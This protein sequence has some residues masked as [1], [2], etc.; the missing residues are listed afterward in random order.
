MS[1]DEILQKRRYVRR[2]DKNAK[3]PE[4]LINSLLQRTWRVT[5]SKNN[6]MPYMVHVIG[7]KPEHQKYKEAVYLNAAQNEGNH[8]GVPDPLNERYSENL[9]NYHNILNC[10]YLIIPTLRLE[11][12]PNRFQQYLI[13]RGHKYEATDPKAVDNLYASAA[14]EV[15]LFCD[16][17]SA[18]CLENDI[19]V[20]F[21]GCFSKNMSTWTELPFLK[22]PPLILMTVGKGELYRQEDPTMAHVLKNDLR[23]DYDRIVNF[24]RS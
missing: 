20:S 10:S 14:F 2:Y 11:D 8:D 22:K 7:N 3:I 13:K 9:P 23:P 4:S 16:T 19:D 18:L 21:T 1:I 5:P 12:K 6:F 17:F 24:V 15:G